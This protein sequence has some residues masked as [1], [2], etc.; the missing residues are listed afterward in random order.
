MRFEGD[1]AFKI[2]GKVMRYCTRPDLDCV[3]CVTREEL[4]MAESLGGQPV[5]DIPHFTGQV[6]NCNTMIPAAIDGARS[7]GCDLP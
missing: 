2:R 3:W 7:V 1:I 4:A 6:C 5:S